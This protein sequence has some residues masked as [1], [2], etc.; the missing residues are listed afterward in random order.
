MLATLA[1]SADVVRSFCP[2]RR[3]S[4]SRK[5]NT[6]AAHCRPQRKCSGERDYV[7]FR[8]L[9]VKCAARILKLPRYFWLHSK[10]GSTRSKHGSAIRFINAVYGVYGSVSGCAGP[11]PLELVQGCLGTAKWQ[12][13]LQLWSTPPGKDG[14]CAGK[15]PW[16]SSC[17]GSTC[18]Q[19]TVHLSTNLS[20]LDMRLTG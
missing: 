6:D 12:W 20:K 4:L 19:Y 7:T 9:K 18:L 10:A 16:R 5:N 3:L 13:R 17:S 15:L 8:S 14:A 11:A 1:S 2:K